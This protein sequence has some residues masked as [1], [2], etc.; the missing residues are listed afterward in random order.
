[1]ILR[2][3]AIDEETRSDRVLIGLLGALTVA[4][5]SDHE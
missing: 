3:L 5:F 1:M 4:L 2:G